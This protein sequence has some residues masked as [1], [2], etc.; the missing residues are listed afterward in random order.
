MIKAH[1]LKRGGESTGSLVTKSQVPDPPNGV[2]VETVPANGTEVTEKPFRNRRMQ[3]SMKP[4]PKQQKSELGKF[5]AQKKFKHASSNHVALGG[6]S[7]SHIHPVYTRDMS[8][9]RILYMKQQS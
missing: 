8:P 2:R 9:S 1:L 3:A 5:E 4:S 6:G 7:V